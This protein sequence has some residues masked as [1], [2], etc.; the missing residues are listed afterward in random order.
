MDFPAALHTFWCEV[1]CKIVGWHDCHWWYTHTWT[2]LYGKFLELSSCDTHK[3]Y[4]P[5]IYNLLS[6]AQSGNKKW[7]KG[8]SIFN[9]SILCMRL[10]VCQ[11]NWTFFFSFFISLLSLS[12]SQNIFVCSSEKSFDVFKTVNID[13][14]PI[15]PPSLTLSSPLSAAAG[16]LRFYQRDIFFRWKIAQI[17]DI[18]ATFF[19]F[20]SFLSF[21]HGE[22]DPKIS[23]LR[24]YE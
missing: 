11:L 22:V 10:V 24:Q 12:V 8:K 9:H 6:W 16:I 21:F 17:D 15:F 5:K 19:S 14:R 13:F 1:E 3:V 20:F 2:V 7:R 23:W 18:E 4:L